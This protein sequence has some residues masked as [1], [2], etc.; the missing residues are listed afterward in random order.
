[1]LSSKTDVDRISTKSWLIGFTEA[2]GYFFFSLPTGSLPASQQAS[3]PAGLPDAGMLGCGVP[4]M[5]EEDIT[6]KFKIKKNLPGIVFIAVGRILGI[7][8]N[9]Q[10]TYKKII[11][12]N[13]RA[14]TNIIKY[15]RNTMKGLKSFEY[16]V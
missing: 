7:R 16:R 9:L 2:K 6:H 1:M 13:S 14:I 10:N 12:A 8:I 4:G 15:F 11:T 5:G 3:R